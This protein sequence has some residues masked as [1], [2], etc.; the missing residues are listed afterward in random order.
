LT[1]CA[2]LE[3]SFAPGGASA[4]AIHVITPADDVYPPARRV[5]ADPK[6]LAVALPGHRYV[7]RI[8]E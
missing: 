7:K 5:I 8:R 2:R 4:A 6:D 3:D 1:P